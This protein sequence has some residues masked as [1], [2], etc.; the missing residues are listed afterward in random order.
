MKRSI[1]IFAII[2][3][4]VSNV[5]A[6]RKV[7]PVEE[8]KTTITTVEGKKAAKELLD[9]KVEP[10]LIF[11]DSIITLPEELAEDTIKISKNTQPL[12]YEASVGVDIWDPL[13]R[14]FGQKYGLFSVTGEMNFHN[15]Y[16]PVVEIGLGHANSTPDDGNFTYKTPLSFFFKVGA[17]YNFLYK[18]NPD[19]KLLGGFR[20]GYSS[21]TYDITDISANSGYWG[22]NEHFEILD[23]KSNALWG[24]FTL[25]LKVK[26][27]K[28]ISM[29]WNFKYRVMFNCKKNPNSNPWYIP[30]YGTESQ[31]FG[32]SYSIFYNFSLNKKK[33]DTST[34]ITKEL[35]KLPEKKDTKVNDES[36]KSK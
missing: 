22:D 20:L 24:E 16:I 27:Y 3:I 30:G 2:I 1:L 5:F 21:F 36:S 15:R 13:M 19:Y 8:T 26:I 23:Q 17:S 25:G 34:E 10:H 32:A 9:K 12:L 7:T 6:Q 4:A 31:D 28:Q 11:S 29:G 18:G 35:N 14:L 33:A